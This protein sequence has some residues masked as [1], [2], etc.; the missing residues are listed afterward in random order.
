MSH[1]LTIVED[2]QAENI[3]RCERIQTNGITRRTEEDYDG[4]NV[5]SCEKCD[6]RY[7]LFL[8]R[9]FTETFAPFWDQWVIDLRAAVS[10]EH[11][12]GH[13]TTFFFHDGKITPGTQ[14][15]KLFGRW[16]RS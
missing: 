9:R 1:G 12:I 5:L 6:A 11:N 3:I 7:A 2:S 8:R 16:L 10:A 14:S 4:P 13:P 15:K